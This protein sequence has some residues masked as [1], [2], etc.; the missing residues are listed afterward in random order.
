MTRLTWWCG[1]SLGVLAAVGCNKKEEE[2]KEVEV[3][4]PAAEPAAEDT[5]ALEKAAEKWVDEEFQPS[6][7]SRAQQLEE[8]KWFREAAKPYR[9]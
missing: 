8:L 7:L 4:A 5:S 1:L 6:T 3:P 9:G 2:R